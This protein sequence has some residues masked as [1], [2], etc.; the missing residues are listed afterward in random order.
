MLHDTKS[1]A[2]KRRRRLKTIRP[3]TADE[4]SSAVLHFEVVFLSV[5]ENASRRGA[6]DAEG[7]VR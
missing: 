5:A 1:V 7:R 2:R 3:K 6:E 4:Q